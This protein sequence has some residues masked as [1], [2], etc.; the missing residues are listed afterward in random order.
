TALTQARINSFLVER[1]GWNYANR[2]YVLHH[3]LGG[4]LN[5]PIDSP[6][7]SCISCHGR[8]GNYAGPIASKIGQPMNMAFFGAAKP[9]VYPM[10]KFDEFFKPIR[11]GAHLE[12]QDGDSYMTTDYS[13]QLSAGIRNYYQNQRSP[14]PVVNAAPR[15]GAVRAASPSTATAPLEPLR[16]VNRDGD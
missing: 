5:G 14:T 8:A 15:A 7:S 13:L 10:A 2:A 11:G 4:R 1:D 16:A 12:T 3:G 9:S 6:V